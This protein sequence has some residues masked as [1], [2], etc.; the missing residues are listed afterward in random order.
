[1]GLIQIP[2]WVLDEGREITESH[3]VPVPEVS[4]PQDR[5]RVF[6]AKHFQQSRY[7]VSADLPDSVRKFST[8]PRIPQPDT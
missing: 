1:V 6:L 7:S 3:N 5:G 4:Q 2:I 8:A